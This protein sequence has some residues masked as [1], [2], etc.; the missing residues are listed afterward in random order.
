[1]LWHF[2]YILLETQCNNFVQIARIIDIDCNKKSFL[3]TRNKGHSNGE[4]KLEYGISVLPSLA[5]GILKNELSVTIPELLWKELVAE[6][7]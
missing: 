6:L 7:S 3:N 5:P 2:F 4:S 1:M